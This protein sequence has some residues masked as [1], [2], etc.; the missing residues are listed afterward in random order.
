MISKTI[1][2]D[3][4]AHGVTC[5]PQ[6]LSPQ[7]I[8]RLTAATD[9]ALASAPDD[10]EIYEGSRAT[11]LSYGELQVW[12]RLSPFR[13]AIFEGSL[14]RLAAEAMSSSSARFLYDQLL[15][16][17]P[18]STRRTPWHQDIPYW[19]VSGRQ[20]CS[21]WFALD[22]IPG[23]AAL[24]F[25]R[26]SHVWEEHNPQ[27]FMDASSYEGTGLAA[28]PEIEAAR[29]HYDI[30]AFDLAPG[31]ALIFQAATVHGAPPAGEAAR[32]RAWSTRWLGDDAIFAEKPGERAFPGDDAGL[33]HGKPYA[34]P[35]YPLIHQGI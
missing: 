24:E 31:D 32:R 13:E 4:Q 20:V 1:L 8:E 25:V 23:S 27:H 17:E 34:G 15:V 12:E 5:V 29:T 30:A 22:P 35:N 3:Y 18:G 14:A 9:A 28:L 7:W 10:T 16:K 2:A 6:V 19:K 26:G 11:P 33:E 21:I